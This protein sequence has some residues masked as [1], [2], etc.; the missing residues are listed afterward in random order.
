M[1]AKEIIRKPEMFN[2]IEL[3]TFKAEFPQED[4]QRTTLYHI[5]QIVHGYSFSIT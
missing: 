1:F 3:A 4:H 5:R 2:S